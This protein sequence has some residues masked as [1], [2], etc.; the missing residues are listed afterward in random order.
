VTNAVTTAMT[1]TMATSMTTAS[2]QLS[3]SVAKHLLSDED[4]ARANWY[5]WFAS[6]WLNA[7]STEQIA[8]WQ[9]SFIEGDTSELGLAWG[10]VVS[11]ATS[12]GAQEIQAEYDSLFVSV[13]KPEVFAY[14]SFHLSGFLHE[15]PLAEI[16]QRMQ[17]L[18]LGG[19]DLAITEDH[20]GLLCATMRELIV[21]NSEGQ[22][23]FVQ[24]F[25]ASWLENLVTALEVSPRAKFYK[26]V[27]SL[28]RVFLAIEV[29]SF[30]FE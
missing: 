19:F 29:Q 27:A 5:A 8:N 3:K 28:W 15:K 22:A 30:D 17:E 12:L 13:G 21:K 10:S 14:A 9:A 2:I 18:G 11:S 24:D 16:R 4:N 26:S 6:I 20:L 25:L 7:P 1:N 23:A